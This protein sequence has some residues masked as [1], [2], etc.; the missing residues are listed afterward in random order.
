MAPPVMT[1]DSV[2]QRTNGSKLVDITYTGVDNDGGGGSV[3]NDI[4]QYE[5]SLNDADWYT[6]TDG[7][8]DSLHD[9]ILALLFDPDGEQYVFVWDI[10]IDIGEGVEDTT[11]YVRLK[12][13]NGVDSNLDKSSAFTVD[14]EDPV[15]SVFKVADLSLLEENVLDDSQKS[16]VDLDIIATGATQMRFSVNV[17]DKYPS[18]NLF[19]GGRFNR[20]HI[21]SGQNTFLGAPPA[22]PGIDPG[23]LSSDVGKFVNFSYGGIN[24]LEEIETFISKREITLK[25]FVSP[26]TSNYN[27]NFNIGTWSNWEAYSTSKTIDMTDAQYGGDDFHFLLKMKREGY[28]LN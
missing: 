15:I 25:D 5:Y 28:G 26:V 6:M 11:T 2:S 1:I 12:S 21:I 7:S 10:L 17:R 4:V 23:F 16:S 24:Y 3:S 8:G 20:G 27:I 13:N 14:T 19:N 9:G 18:G 22:G